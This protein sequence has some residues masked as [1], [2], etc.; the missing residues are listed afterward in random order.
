MRR[1]ALVSILAIAAALG[2]SACSSGQSPATTTQS[3]EIKAI[4]AY[5]DPAAETMMRSFQNSSLAEYVQ[6]GDAQFKAAVSQAVFDQLATPMRGQ[7]GNFVSLEFLSTEN[8]QG[9]LI[10]H[11]KA[12]FQKGQ[13]GLRM[14]FDADHLVAG[15]FFE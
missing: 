3:A 9:Y 6:K 1:L 2:V 7:Y 4:R 14:V 15:Q 12:K 13:L 11:Y 5:A 10:V 8:Q